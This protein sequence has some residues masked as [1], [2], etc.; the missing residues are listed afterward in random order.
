[1]MTHLFLEDGSHAI[2]KRC[3][4]TGREGPATPDTET[5][6]VY[7]DGW[8]GYLARP[9]MYKIFPQHKVKEIHITREAGELWGP[10]N[11]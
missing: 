1:M 8:V 4:R 5:L 9:R 7:P 3:D 6:Y 2:F 10:G 11:G